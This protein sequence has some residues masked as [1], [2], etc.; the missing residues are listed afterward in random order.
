MHILRIKDIPNVTTI[1]I[2]SWQR[3][4]EMQYYFLCSV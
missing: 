2:E 3:L 1:L 4:M